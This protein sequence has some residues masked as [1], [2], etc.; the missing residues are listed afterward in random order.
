L[1]LKKA[2]EKKETAPAETRRAQDSQSS[3]EPPPQEVSKKRARDDVWFNFHKICDVF[4]HIVNTQSDSEPVSEPKR[5]KTSA[6]PA[7]FFDSGVTPASEVSVASADENNAVD[8][9]AEEE[10]VEETIEEVVEIRRNNKERFDPD[11]IEREVMM[12]TAGQ[13]GFG[14]KL[15]DNFV[16]RARPVAKPPPS[17]PAQTTTDVEYVLHLLTIQTQLTTKSYAF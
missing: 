8:G 15:P 10:N 14:S 11:E 9:N 1:L 5:S 3:E 13:G 17:Q 16:D 12:E 6:L 7:D 4:T 2:K